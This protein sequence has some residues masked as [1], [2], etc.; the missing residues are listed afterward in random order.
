ML[1]ELPFGYQGFVL[2]N[3]LKWLLDASL[4]QRWQIMSSM[5]IFEIAIQCERGNGKQSI[6]KTQRKHQTPY[7]R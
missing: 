4:Y 7:I 2:N 3:R 5:L 1:L 6:D